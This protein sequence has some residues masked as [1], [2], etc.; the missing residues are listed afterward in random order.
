L[1]I[2]INWHTHSVVSSGQLG[3]GLHDAGGPVVGDVWAN[4]FGWQWT[5]GAWAA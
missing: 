3:A 1:T 5:A 4:V 2:C